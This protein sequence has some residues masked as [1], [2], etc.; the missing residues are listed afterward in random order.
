MLRT[1]CFVAATAFAV[2]PAQAA[3]IGV[4]SIELYQSFVGGQAFQ[5]QSIDLNAYS[6]GVVTSPL[7]GVTGDTAW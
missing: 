1:T 4:N 7:Q 3:L 6:V 5:D 2:S